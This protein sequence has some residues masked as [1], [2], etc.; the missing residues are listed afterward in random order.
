MTNPDERRSDME[1]RLVVRIAILES[2]QEEALRI[3]LHHET[4]LTKL[5]Q[6]DS[7]MLAA[8]NSISSKF[9]ALLK[10]IATGFKVLCASVGVIV[11]AIGAFW[12][13]SL[14]LDQKFAPKLEQVSQDVRAS[15]DHIKQQKER[16][17]DIVSDVEVIKRKK[18]VRASK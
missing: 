12:T 9:D 6:K 8:L 3:R 11:T 4:E 14:N 18:S 15:E 10:Q 16:V 17:A 13:Y 2:K 7:E 5:A 1:T